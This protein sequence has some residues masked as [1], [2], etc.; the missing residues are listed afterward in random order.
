[1]RQLTIQECGQLV[2]LLLACPAMQDSHQR[3]KC[4]RLS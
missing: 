4:A 1:M 2:E 3:G